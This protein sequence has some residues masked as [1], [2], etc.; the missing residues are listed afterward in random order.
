MTDTNDGSDQMYPDNSQEPQNLGGDSGQGADV[1]GQQIR[2]RQLS[3]RV[4]DAVGRGAFSTGAVVLTGA[5]EFV[6][7]F[8]VRMARPYQI[9]ARVVLPHASMVQLIRALQ[10]NLGKYENRFGQIPPMPRADPKVKRPSIQ[11]IYDDLKLPDESLSGVYANACI[12]G[13]SPAEFV[14][15]F[16]TNFFPRSAV[17]A[18]IY[19]SARQAPQLLKSLQHAAQQLD[20]RIRKAQLDKQQDTNT[21]QIPDLPADTPDQSP[22]DSVDD[23]PREDDAGPDRVE[24]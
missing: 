14:L 15:D 20:Q 10:D 12:I 6:V 2:H 21:T 5:S 13:H 16:V 1:F 7:D 11:E 8:L 4:P 9:A 23:D 17:S 18:R 24:G 22:D 3:A 19:L